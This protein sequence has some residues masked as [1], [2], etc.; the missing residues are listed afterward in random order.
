MKEEPDI[1]KE[2]RQQDKLLKIEEGSD[3]SSHYSKKSV[4]LTT[5]SPSNMQIFI[6]DESQASRRSEYGL[7]DRT[8][9][10]DER[11]KTLFDWSPEAIVIINKS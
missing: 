2:L 8:L 7:I 6:D 11:N 1:V 3:R 9:M 4:D 5:D 10:G